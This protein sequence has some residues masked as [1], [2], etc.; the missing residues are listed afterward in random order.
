MEKGHSEC[1][2]VMNTWPIF[3]KKIIIKLS[4][5]KARPPLGEALLS[6]GDRGRILIIVELWGFIA[7]KNI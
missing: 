5:K 3:N 6:I 7:T 2:S 1:N 4:Q